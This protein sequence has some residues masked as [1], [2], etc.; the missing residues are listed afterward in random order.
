MMMLNWYKRGVRFFFVDFGSFIGNHLVIV[1]L[2]CHWLTVWIVNAGFPSV[3]IVFRKK[4][5]RKFKSG[6]KKKWK[7]EKKPNCPITSR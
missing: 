7:I 3:S 6:T 1:W 2:M 4:N 5:G